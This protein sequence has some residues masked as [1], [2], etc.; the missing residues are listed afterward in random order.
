MS[1][2]PA[3]RGHLDSKTIVLRSTKLPIKQR[4]V[5]NSWDIKSYHCTYGRWDFAYLEISKA[6]G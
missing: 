3:I 4:V 6:Q 5:A 2:R 1:T